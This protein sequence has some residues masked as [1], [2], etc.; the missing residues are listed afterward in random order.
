MGIPTSYL[1]GDSTPSPLK[2][3]FVAFLRD[4]FDFAI[5]VLLCDARLT[6]AAQHVAKLSEVT[7]KEIERAE[8]LATDVSRALDSAA[9][10]D[11]ES[12]A[13][14]CAARIRQGAKDLIRL[15]AE[16]A[17]AAVAAEKARASQA[18]AGEH[19]SAVKA[20]EALLM[21]HTLPDS[22]AVMRIG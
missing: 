9:V 7:E 13:A 21:R 8:T 15:E 3:D 17:R 5:T 20:L 18:M 6:D 12:L 22:V 16:G 14:R 4:A 10:G 2:T 1:Y 11:Q 19:D